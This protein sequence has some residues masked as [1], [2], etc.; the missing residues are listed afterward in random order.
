MASSF[1]A[2][3]YTNDKGGQQHAGADASGS[4]SPGAEDGGRC[5]EIS[6][7]AL[8][9]MIER[10]IIPRLY[11]AHSGCA[12]TAR[13]EPTTEDKPPPDITD[14]D[15]F[16]TLVLNSDTKEILER[17]Q[18]LV[19]CGIGLRRI[20]LDLLAPV[21]RRIGEFW[22]QDRCTFVD[23][24]IGL[25]RLQQVLREIGRS[26]GERHFGPIR[27]RRA[28]LVPAPGEQH[29]FGLSM[30]EEF[31]LQAGWEA[32]SDTAASAQA[33]IQNVSHQSL[34]V[35]GFTLGCEA[36]LER[37]LEFIPKARKASLN[38]NVAVMVGGRL[39]VDHPTIASRVAA[40][41]AVVFDGGTAVARVEDLLR[42]KIC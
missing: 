27:K 31:F 4:E 35:I 2:D 39:F 40:P 34:D 22:E 14:Q 10:E 8:T 18:A 32:D 20:Y 11:L 36:F 1:D 23:V 16:A 13:A 37:L 21:A 3:T 38:K 25:A 12:P 7:A 29:T 9:R 5:S 26:N 24:T 19:D 28:Y 6:E 15:G 33:I 42:P 41:T 30:V 17:I